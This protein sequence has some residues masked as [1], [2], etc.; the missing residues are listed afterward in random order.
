MT[1]LPALALSVAALAACGPADPLAGDAGTGSDAGFVV[2]T[3]RA[4]GFSTASPSAMT[5]T[6]RELSLTLGAATS[7]GSVST[8]MTDGGGRIVV[9]VGPCRFEAPR[10]VISTPMRPGTH[11]YVFPGGRCVVM[12]RT[13]AMSLDITS[14][15]IY[16]GID[17]DGVL[18]WSA[19]LSVTFPAV[20]GR[21][22]FP[23]SVRLY[24]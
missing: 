21:D 16:A 10:V 20:D 9:E 2:E 13:G 22:G 4:E 12:A 7:R 24:R 17:L 14:G 11:A 23:W 18:L 5:Q 3:F 19:E 8:P 15:R 1:R 6:A